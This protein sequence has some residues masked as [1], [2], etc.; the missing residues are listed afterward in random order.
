MEIKNLHFYD[1]NGYELNFDFNETRNCWEGN[2]YL[3]PVSIGLYSN[4]TVF[5]LEEVYVPKNNNSYKKH[6]KE[7]ETEKSYVF[8]RPSDDVKNNKIEFRWDSVNNF[9]DEIFMFS[10]DQNYKSKSHTALSYNYND[11]P[12]CETSYRQS[13]RGKMCDRYQGSW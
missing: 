2:I 10:F 5:V 6:F 1:R 13:Y 9:V 3:P 8:P 12:D 11:G 4:S 7:S